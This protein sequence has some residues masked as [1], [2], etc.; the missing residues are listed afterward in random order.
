MG[1]QIKKATRIEVL[2]EMHALYM[3]LL[4]TAVTPT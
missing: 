3:P 2:E 4:R 1:Q